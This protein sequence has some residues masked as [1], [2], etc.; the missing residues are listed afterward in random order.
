[1]VRDARQ[2]REVSRRAVYQRIGEDRRKGTGGSGELTEQGFEAMRLCHFEAKPRNLVSAASARFLA[3]LGMT[4]FILSSDSMMPRMETRHSQVSRSRNHVSK[5][6]G[7]HKVSLDDIIGLSAYEKIR[8]KF[9]REIIELK[10]KR[11]IPVGPRVSLVFENR[12]T[13]IFQVQEML[14]AE[15][16][17]RSRQNQGGTRGLQR[18]HSRSGRVEC[19]DVPRD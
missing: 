10:Q 12:Q 14:R 4:I 9:R 11:R 6:F 7:M 19:D 17:H 1:M 13:V 5:D 3:P 2:S 18:S 8:D 15:K 16:N